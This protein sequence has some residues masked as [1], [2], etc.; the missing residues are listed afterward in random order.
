M[1][2]TQML[3]VCRAVSH[4]YFPVVLPRC[5]KTDIE[6]RV[7]KLLGRELT[8]DES[9][10][11]ENEY[12]QNSPEEVEWRSRNLAREAS[13]YL[14]NVLQVF[15]R[16][17]SSLSMERALKQIRELLISHPED[18]DTVNASLDDI[19]TMLRAIKR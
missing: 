9:E 18:S 3:A 15:N 2:K 16:P 13:P 10:W 6:D 1:D 11:L 17:D 14:P 19:D 8:E 5:T 7:C 4:W 12:D